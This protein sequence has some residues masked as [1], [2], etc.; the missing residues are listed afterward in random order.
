[1]IGSWL[2]SLERCLRENKEK[3]REEAFWRQDK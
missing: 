1:M 2:S 3:I